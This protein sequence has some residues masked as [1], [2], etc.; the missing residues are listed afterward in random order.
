LSLENAIE[1]HKGEAEG[2]ADRFFDLTETQQQ[3]LITFLNSL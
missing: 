1:R 3:Q 2:V